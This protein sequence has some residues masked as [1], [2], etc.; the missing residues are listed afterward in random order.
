[1]V[2]AAAMSA[3]AASL[4]L[5]SVRAGDGAALWTGGGF[6]QHIDLTPGPRD[7]VRASVEI[8]LAVV[9]SGRGD[10]GTF[11]LTVRTA[12]PTLRA[13]V[14]GQ[15]VSTFPTTIAR[16]LTLSEIVALDVVVERGGSS[17]AT[18]PLEFELQPLGADFG[19]QVQPGSRVIEARGPIRTIRR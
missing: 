14:D 15:P 8:Q 19:I 4:E 1:M 7:R 9:R 16:G 18:L 12:D 11:E 3:W 5:V 6:S 2:L 10:R 17:T 13:T